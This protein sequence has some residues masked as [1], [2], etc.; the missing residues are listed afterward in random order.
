MKDEWL[1]QEWV[2][3]HEEDGPDTRVFRP[4]TFP[5]PPSRGRRTLDLRVAGTF[6]GTRPGADDRRESATG[7]WAIAGNTL[8]LQSRDSSGPP[9]TLEIVSLAADRLVLKTR[10]G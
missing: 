7:P 8:T 10:R 4:S 2:H 3:A 5:L 9:E 1:R 6:E